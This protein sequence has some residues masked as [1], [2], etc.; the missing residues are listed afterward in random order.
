MDIRIKIA[1]ASGDKID[2]TVKVAATGCSLKELRKKAKIDGRMQ[3]TVNG[4]PADDKRH[5][6]PDDKV[7]FTERV[8]GS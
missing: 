5:I 4:E 6:G 1:P 2:K 7:V 3:A 8:S